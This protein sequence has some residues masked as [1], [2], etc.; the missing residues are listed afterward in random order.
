[1]PPEHMDHYEARLEAQA[2]GS[3]R[4]TP[5]ALAAVK[6]E[7]ATK[8]RH[9]TEA[10]D[11]ILTVVEADPVAVGIAPEGAAKARR[12]LVQLQAITVG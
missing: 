10:L 5:E 1:M 4:L 3:P 9:E 7:N 12:A 11:F 8:R 6:A 2:H